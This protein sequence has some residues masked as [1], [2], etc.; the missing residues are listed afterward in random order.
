VETKYKVLIIE[1]ET[2]IARF[3]Q[4]ELAHEG[5]EVHAAYSG[6][7]GFSLA[8]KNLP[9]LIVLDII[10]PDISGLEV[11]RRL[12]KIQS[13]P[14]IMLTAK[15]QIGDRVA[16][17]DS[18]ADDYLT[19]PF[20]IDELLARIRALIRRS[21]TKPKGE[22]LMARD[23]VLNPLTHEVRR[24]NKHIDLTAKEFAL[25]EFLLRNKGQVLT[26]EL[27]FEEVWGYDFIGESNII[28]VYIRY[29]RDKVDCDPGKELIHTV[30]G[31]GYVVKD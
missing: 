19:K 10:L 7:E 16:G 3:L 11:C 20:H 13:T 28:D 17:L 8:Q 25:L 9:D 30:R 1:D 31:V 12:R 29:L 5:Y 4:L 15:D 22:I 18:G 23:L 14:I 24:G 21:S 6:D 26:R 27:I 2:E